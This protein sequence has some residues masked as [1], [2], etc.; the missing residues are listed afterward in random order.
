ML[1]GG[2]QLEVKNYKLSSPLSSPIDC[3]AIQRLLGVT[4]KKIMA[5]YL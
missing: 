2:K 5:K 1:G 4:G 3:E